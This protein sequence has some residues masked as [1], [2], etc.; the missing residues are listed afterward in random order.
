[1][2]C[3][4]CNNT[5][6]TDY[7]YC[8]D[9]GGK[10]VRQ[11]ITNKSLIY[12]FLE[13]YFNLDNTFLKTIWH[14]L[15]KPEEV[16]GGYISGLRKKYLNPVSML[17]ISLTAS[18][19]IL[20]LMK[21][22]AWGNIDFSKISYVQTSSGGAGTEKIMASTMEY[23]SLLFLFYIP[24]LAFAS[25]VFFNKKNY[26]LAEHMVTAIYALTSFSIISAVYA[27]ITLLISPQF[28][29]DVALIYSLVMVLFCGYVA[30]R[31]SLDK[32]TSLFW[33]VPLFLMVFLV[34]Y[35]G[36]S[37][38]TLGALLITGEISFQDFMPAK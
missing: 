21:K 11:R 17:A 13:R 8:P 5:L 26:N 28:Y 2:N 23:S 9:C 6:R 31:N 7:S 4:N 32:K 20:F 18:G 12:D 22:L 29:I 24:V 27:I 34:G 15:I 36:I 16:C 1:M 3:K 14:M 19:F 33:R 35:F 30:Y 10:V 37:I 25:Y 38:L